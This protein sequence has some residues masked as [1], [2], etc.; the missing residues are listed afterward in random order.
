MGDFGFDSGWGVATD[1]SGNITLVGRFQGTVDFGGGP[2]TGAGD[3]DVFVASYTTDAVHRW[4]KAFGGP[5]RDYSFGIAVDNEDNT[6]ITG[7]FQGSAN[8]GGNVLTSAGSNDIFMAS[9]DSKGAHRW[10]R[11]LGGTED[12]QGRAVATDGSGN[13]TI[14]GLF[15]GSVD[16]GAGPVV[17][18]L[19]SDVFVASYDA[20]GAHRWSRG[21]GGV[22]ADIGHGVTVDSGGNVTVTGGFWGTANFGGDPLIDADNGDIFVASYTTKGAHRW[23][24]AFNSNWSNY[25]KAVAADDDGNVTLT[26]TF[27]LSLDFGG[28]TLVS[29][30]NT[31]VFVA[32]FSAKGEHRWSKALGS[33]A[34]DKGHGITVDGGGNVFV[35]G[36]F[37]DTADFG[38]GLTT[39]A[40]LR[41]IFVASYSLSGAHRWSMRFGGP[42][43]DEGQSV[44]VDKNGNVAL[45][46]YFGDSID[47]GGN[48]LTSV[49]STD[50]FLARFVP[51]P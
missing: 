16:F 49:G 21:A 45:T 14:T 17:G 46:G 37:Q 39:S 25:G 28:G 50:V 26:G 6:V 43:L 20:S 38:G 5:T 35:T 3:Y 1:R 36:S 11:G 47:F 13:I 8:F 31:D 51:Q 27:G 34:P 40:G 41:D 10:S 24:K 19:S 22:M 12:D 15:H 7:H 4:S 23:S 30:G 18:G 29:K 42:V 32:S 33:T 48:T 44:A 2:L 9:Y